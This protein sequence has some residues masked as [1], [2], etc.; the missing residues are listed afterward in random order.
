MEAYGSFPRFHMNLKRLSCFFWKAEIL[1][2]M[3]PTVCLFP[4]QFDGS[5]GRPTT[6][7]ASA[8]ELCDV[9]CPVRWCVRC[10]FATTSWTGCRM[11]LMNTAV[12]C[13]S[14]W[15]ASMVSMAPRAVNRKKKTHLFCVCVCVS[16]EQAPRAED[17]IDAFARRLSQNFSAFLGNYLIVCGMCICTFLY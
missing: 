11:L 6:G 15:M 3:H 13:G 10:G 12:P 1:P 5:F 14:C 17:G 16:C 8:C 4:Y 7:K 9:R 2:R